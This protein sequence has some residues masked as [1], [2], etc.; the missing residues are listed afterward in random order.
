[1]FDYSDPKAPWNLRFKTSNNKNWDIFEIDWPEFNE[2][3]QSYMNIGIP[4]TADQK[5]RYRYMKFWNKELQNE[6]KYATEVHAKT[7]STTTTQEPVQLVYNEG[8]VNPFPF[9]P[10][11]KQ[12]FNSYDIIKNRMSTPSHPSSSVQNAQ[13]KTDNVETSSTSHIFVYILGAIII[14][15]IIIN[16]VFLSI[17]VWNKWKK[18][19]QSHDET[20]YDKT[21]DENDKRI[22]QNEFYVA[23]NRTHTQKSTANDL[24][25]LVKISNYSGVQGTAATR[26]P[27][28]NSLDAHAKVVDWIAHDIDRINNERL[29][30]RPES[31][32]QWNNKN[33][34]GKVSIGIDATPQGRSDSVLNQ[35]PIEISKGKSYD[36]IINNNHQ[37]SIDSYENIT[38]FIEDDASTVPSHRENYA[39]LT[40]QKQ[41]LPKVLPNFNDN[42]M[43]LAMKRRSLPSHA[44]YQAQQL[45]AKIPP[46]PPPRTTSTLGRKPSTRRNSINITT[47]PLKL[48]EEPPDTKEPEITCNILHVGPL[49]PKS[50]SLYSTISRKRPVSDTNNDSAESTSTSYQTI[51]INRNDSRTDIK[52]FPPDSEKASNN[53]ERASSDSSDSSSIKTVKT[54]YNQ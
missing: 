3:F 51:E 29:L 53:L 43:T 50:D 20:I 48:A 25:E 49:I 9:P 28:S 23:T 46:I 35:V 26:S 4:P 30:N 12:K 44:F 17:F 1:M 15:F 52:K 45:Q 38:S 40:I 11:T 47:S 33:Y 41:N 21:I 14:L 36:S 18:L 31:P 27:H 22:K 2:N 8:I 32:S 37:D 6:L 24:Y 16:L 39:L 34:V 10:K 19:K 7:T 42:D 13:D 5:Y 54:N